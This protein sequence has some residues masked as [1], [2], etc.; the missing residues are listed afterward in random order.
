MTLLQ[1]YLKNPDMCLYSENI[2]NRHTVKQTNRHVPRQASANGRGDLIFFL[3]VS[4]FHVFG[5]LGQNCCMKPGAF[6]LKMRKTKVYPPL[7]P[8]APGHVLRITEFL[9][10]KFCN[11]SKI[12]IFIVSCSEVCPDGWTHNVWERLLI[13]EEIPQSDPVCE[14]VPLSERF[15]CMPQDGTADDCAA[16][17]CCWE[18]LKEVP[19][20]ERPYPGRQVH[21]KPVDSGAPLNV[22]YCY[23]PHN[24]QGYFF[25]NFTET[26]YGLVGYMQRNKPASPYHQDVLILRMDVYFETE[27][28]IRVRITDPLN[29]RWE[30]PLPVVPLM[31][32]RTQKSRLHYKFKVLENMGAFKIL[33]KR[34]EVPIFDTISAAP[35]QYADQFIELSSRLPSDYIYGLGEHLDGLLLDT[36][37]TK[38]VMWNLDQIPEPGKYI[39]GDLLF[40]LLCDLAFSPYIIFDL[41]SDL[42]VILQPTPAVTFRT[43]GGIIDL[44]VFL[45]PTP[46]EV[47]SQY[48]EIIGRP[49]LPPYWSLGYHQ[50]RYQYG[51]L[52]ETR[53]VWQRTRNAGIPFDTQWNDLD[54][55]STAKDFT[56][57]HEKFSGLPE[58]VKELH[59]VGMHYIPII[60]PGISAAEHKDTY[61][62]WDEG[63]KLGVFVRNISDQPFIGKVWNPVATVWPDFTHRY[64]TYYWTKQIGRYHAEVPIDGAWIDMNEPSNFWSGESNGC[65]DTNLDNPPYLPAVHGGV[66]YYHTICMSAKHFLGY[67]YNIHNLYG[68]T[69]TISTNLAL[70]IVR[71]KRPFVISRSTFPGQGHFGGHWTGDVMSDWFN[72]WQ[73]I[74][75]ILE[76]SVYSVESFTEMNSKTIKPNLTLFWV[77]LSLYIFEG[78]KNVGDHMARNLIP[79][80]GDLDVTGSK[81]LGNGFLFLSL[82]YSVI[83]SVFMSPQPLAGPMCFN[84]NVQNTCS[85]ELCT[86]WGPFVILP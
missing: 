15:D 47:I 28:R 66:L 24:Y 79:T 4:G 25:T 51:S 21:P 19:P 48:T 18:T 57:D 2:D 81:Y 69:E 58:F 9:N 52:N 23:Y 29:S 84:Y 27:T 26:D 41:K 55:M 38:R 44:F 83:C 65:P 46:N 13:Y 62:P 67:H 20:R 34:S 35:L 30:S 3:N 61:L 49:F 56:Y 6:V 60:D 64:A 36:Y 32:T 8:S 17:G 43:T 7:T 63:I 68:F 80:P 14:D 39:Y 76:H 71:N 85:T 73:S 16:R 53:K 10:I 5:V 1:S 33:R 42:L 77:K 50:C 54:Y 72:L 40:F 12:L 78:F 59:E 37:W 74:P 70:S 75:V 45:G 82:L 22:P 86:E 31:K 11:I